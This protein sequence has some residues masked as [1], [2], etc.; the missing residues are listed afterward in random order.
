MRMYVILVISVL[1]VAALIVLTDRVVRISRTV[2]QARKRREVADRLAV[3]VAQ[4]EQEQAAKDEVKQVSTA[5]TTVL[6][7]IQPEDVERTPRHV[8]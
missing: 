8:A 5:L 1:L 7:V 3:V 4:A 6:P 2:R